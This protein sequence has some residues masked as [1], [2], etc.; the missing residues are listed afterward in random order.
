MEKGVVLTE[1]DS[2]PSVLRAEFNMQIRRKLIKAS[3]DEC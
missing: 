1:E 3:K 2:S